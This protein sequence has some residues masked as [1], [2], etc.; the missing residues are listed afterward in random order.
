MVAMI[1]LG[2]GLG[3]VLPEYI[4]LR[5]MPGLLIDSRFNLAMLEF[6]YRTLIDVLHDRHADFLNAPFFY[7]WP[8]VTNFSDTFWGDW[9]AYA[10]ARG[11]GASEPTS[12]QIWVIAGFAITYVAT[13]LSFRKLEMRPWGAAAGAFLFAFALPMTA[14][15]YHSQLTYRL[16]IAPAV[17]ALDRLLTK[18][19]LRAGAACVLFLALQFAAS[20]Y[21]GLFLCLLLASYGMAVF[22]VGR[23]RLALPSINE[24]RSVGLAEHCTT[25]VLFL[26]GLI[27][28]AVV[29]VPYHEVKSLYGFERSWSEAAS[30]LPRLGSYVLAESRI[31][32]DF[33]STFPYLYGRLFPGMV[34]IVPLLFFLISRR[35]RKRQPVAIA[36]LVTVAI[37]FFLTIYVRGHTIYWIIYSIPGFSAMRY[38]Y[39][40]VL[41]LLLPLAALLGMLIDDLTAPGRYRA[42]RC[43]VASLLSAFLIAECS[44]VNLHSSRPA[45]WRERLNALEAQLPKNLPQGAVLAVRS[46]PLGAGP[47]QW[48]IEQ[49]DAQLAA[50]AHG[51]ATMNGYSSNLPPTWRSM[52]TCSDVDH[53][54]RVGRRFLAEHGLPAADIAPGQLVL[55]GFE[56]CNLPGSVASRHSSSA[57]LT[58]LLWMPME[59]TSWLMVSPLPSIGVAGPTE[60]TRSCFS[61]SK[62]QRQDRCPSPSTPVRFLLRQTAGKR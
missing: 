21:L 11:L 32:P 28:L 39:R 4:T 62:R 10:L 60:A 23:D 24:I 31:W 15:V 29:A 7:P 35:A 47:Q 9:E 36:M 40:V 3:L 26:I 6:F 58:I 27:V 48:M 14:Q 30:S 45:V 33:S 18:N 34:A 46:D 12:F 25:A 20:I 37:L 54:I 1:F 38:V 17:V 22:L 19:S 59:T 53:N 13:F 57:A 52:S 8:R 55:V 42:T 5:A 41:V 51:I 2:L 44:L 16:W 49:V 61:P 43:I 56:P 50:V